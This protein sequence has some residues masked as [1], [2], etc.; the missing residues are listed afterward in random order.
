MIAA[1]FSIP[2]LLLGMLIGVLLGEESRSR[3][4]RP[5]DW[6]AE[7]DKTWRAGYRAGYKYA[8]RKSNQD[9]EDNNG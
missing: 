5:S 3:K 9:T 4:A 2:I 1:V 6:R 7:L 8:M